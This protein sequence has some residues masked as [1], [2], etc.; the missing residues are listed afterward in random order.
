MDVGDI[1]QFTARYTYI[2]VEMLNVF[3]YIVKTGGVGGD[4]ATTVSGSFAPNVLGQV[5]NLQI[6]D[7]EYIDIVGRNHMSLAADVT[8]PYAVTG[9]YVAGS[10]SPTFV[11]IGFR[12]N[13]DSRLTRNG[14][15]RFGGISEDATD[16]NSPNY[17]GTIVADVEAALSADL[18]ILTSLEASV[19]VMTPIIV[20]RCRLS[21]V[22]CTPG[23]LDLTRFSLVSSAQVTSVTTQSSRKN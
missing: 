12:L 10:G 5:R 19:G 3:F 8:V 18:D 22:G 9:N 4:L 15:K 6:S 2:G 13:R 16:V 14:S 7:T 1:L 17:T 21:D 11:S 23:D 20:G